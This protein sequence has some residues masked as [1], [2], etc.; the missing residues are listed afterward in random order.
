MR[1]PCIIKVLGTL[2][3]ICTTAAIYLSSALLAQPGSLDSTFGING[4]QLTPIGIEDR[5]RAVAIQGDGKIVL[6][7]YASDVTTL[8]DFALAR[9]HPNGSL[10]STFGSN[11]KV[12][13]DFNSDH[14][15]G[16]AIVIQPDGKM[17][18]AGYSGSALNQKFA[19]V[20]YNVDGTL[21]NAFGSNGRVTATMGP[22]WG[23]ASDI[24][25]QSDGKIVVVGFTGTLTTSYFA[26]ARFTADGSFDSTFNGNGKQYTAITPFHDQATA[27]AIQSDGR[28][29][30]AGRSYFIDWEFSMARYLPGG[31]LDSTFGNN[32]TVVVSVGTD[33]DEAHAMALQ[34]DGKIVLAGRAQG[35]ANRDFAVARFN[36]NGTIDNS[37]GTGGKVITPLGTGNDDAYAV[38][39]QPSGRIIVGGE[40]RTPGSDFGLLRYLPSGVLDSTF[41]NGGKVITNVDPGPDAVFGLVLQSDGKIVAAGYSKSGSNDHFAVVRY[42]GEFFQN[43]PIAAF[44]SMGSA[45]EGETVEFTSTSQEASDLM[46]TFQGGIPPNSS[47]ANPLVQY[48]TPGTFGITLIAS[49]ALGS[50]TAVAQIVIHPGVHL[51]YS[52][53]DASSQSSS[54]GAINLTISGGTPPFSFAW[55]N[56]AT[57][58]DINNLATGE[59]TVTITD[60]TGCEQTSTIHVPFAVGIGSIHYNA[61]TVKPNPASAFIEIGTNQSLHDATI[62]I[63]DLS[64]RV[65]ISGSFSETLDVSYIP[66]GCYTIRVTSAESILASK[67]VIA[68]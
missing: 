2:P 46:W 15:R 37:F 57:T 10:D 3:T 28:I 56:G 33:D 29:L 66:A 60:D 59:Y 36:A 52:I 12:T 53:T 11:G 65:V 41:G 27:V 34:A 24:A 31:H 7:G 25:L 13:T 62:A 43:P 9:Y 4:K 6:A 68:R 51:S 35:A 54:D 19:V 14:D 5:A 8:E 47:L 26:I 39:V 16:H 45:C 40:A 30:V 50:D 63:T 48:D 44:L 61:L 49:S 17:V 55:S 21:D 58:E 18:V 1:K 20:R 67:V 42:R 32:G 64:G 23:G 38:V 22:G